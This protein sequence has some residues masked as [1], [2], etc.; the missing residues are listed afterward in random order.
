MR[1][2]SHEMPLKLWLKLRPKS[3]DCKAKNVAHIQFY[4]HQVISHCKLLATMGIQGED[5]D[6]ALC[7]LRKLTALN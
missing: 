2:I 3:R 7:A 5:Q 6:E 1:Q 4:K